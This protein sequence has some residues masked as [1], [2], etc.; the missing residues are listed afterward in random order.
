MIEVSSFIEPNDYFVA[1]DGNTTLSDL[2][3]LCKLAERK[4]AHKQKYVDAATNIRHLIE[5]G[6][7]FQTIKLYQLAQQ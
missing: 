5:D 6:Q 2:K 4:K 3:L 7:A 1:P